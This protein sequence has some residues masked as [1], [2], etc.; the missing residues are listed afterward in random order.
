LLHQL[1]NFV[2]G[3]MASW[4][5]VKM[6]I[7]HASII[8]SDSMHVLAGVLIL[9]LSALILRRSILSWLPWL[10]VLAMAVAN[11]AVD[12][13]V[14]QWPD[15]AMQYRESVKDLLLTMTLPTILLLAARFRPQLFRR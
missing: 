15:V 3:G 5:R 9:L 11:E 14:E 4:Y 6:F 12:L 1:R 7:E 2:T 10:I 13:W 8:T